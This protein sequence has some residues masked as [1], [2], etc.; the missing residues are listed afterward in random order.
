MMNGN[1]VELE[2]VDDLNPAAKI[3]EEGKFTFKLVEDY[4]IVSERLT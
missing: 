3:F 2:E 1:A 4:P